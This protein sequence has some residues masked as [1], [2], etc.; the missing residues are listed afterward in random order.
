[1]TRL[2]LTV[3]VT[4]AA[5]AVVG[6]GQTGAIRSTPRT[7]PHRS[8]LAQRLV[9]A[10]LGDSIT[11]GTPQWDPDPAIR[12]QMGDSVSPGSQY[13]YWLGKQLGR[14]A[15]VRNCGVFGERTDQ[16]ALR[17]DSCARGANAVIIQ[18]GINDIAQH[19]DPAA[20]AANLRA[21]VRSAKRMKLAVV[22]ATVL[23][24]NNG[25]PTTAPAIVRLNAAIA[26][27]GHEEKVDVADFYSALDDPGHPGRMRAELTADGDHPSIPGYRLLG[28]LLAR[29]IVRAVRTT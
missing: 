7:T 15:K 2:L 8:P 18:G 11:A 13:E 20:A 6:C 23:P 12:G 19:R 17:L 1:M 16:I 10:A 5:I 26:R 27:I 22:L 14:R 28:E 24:W 4:A 29:P 25:Y 21:L 3:I 9:V